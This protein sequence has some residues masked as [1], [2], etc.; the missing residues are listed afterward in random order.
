VLYTHWRLFQ[1]VETWYKNER[2][3]HLG[4]ARRLLASTTL[5][6][7]R[8]GGGASAPA[9][10]RAATCPMTAAQARLRAHCCAAAARCDDDDGRSATDAAPDAASRV[11]CASAMRLR[12]S[13]LLRRARWRC[14]SW[15]LRR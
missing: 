7:R 15:T 11:R 5:V 8:R 9:P 3:F 10:Q 1:D 12:R 14:V 6:A 13:T 2:L 4:A